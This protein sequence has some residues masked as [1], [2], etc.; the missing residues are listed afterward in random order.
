M[1]FSC[2]PALIIEDKDCNLNFTVEE[3]NLEE[4]M[5]AEALRNIGGFNSHK[6]SQYSFLGSNVTPED[7][8]WIGE[9]CRKAGKLKTPSDDFYNQ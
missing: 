2:D 6:F 8:T 9:I 7:N 3:S 1:I 5:E 4:Q